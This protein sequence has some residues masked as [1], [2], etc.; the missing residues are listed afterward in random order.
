MKFLITLLLI[1]GLSATAQKKPKYY[2][3]TRKLSKD[4]VWLDSLGNIIKK[5][6][7]KKP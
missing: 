2:R 3:V 7:F 6:T 4:T 1:F 5:P